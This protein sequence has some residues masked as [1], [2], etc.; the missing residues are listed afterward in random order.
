MVCYQSLNWILILVPLFLLAED[1]SSSEDENNRQQKQQQALTL[2]NDILDKLKSHSEKIEAEF[3]KIETH[4][5][6]MVTGDPSW[7]FYREEL[8]K[9]VGKMRTMLSEIKT[10]I[11]PL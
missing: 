2:P 5:R 4:F 1:E 7:Q 6:R 8:V 9:R 10:E 3:H 11:D